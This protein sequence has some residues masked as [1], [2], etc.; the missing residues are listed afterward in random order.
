MIAA[1]AP[2]TFVRDY[3][4]STDGEIGDWVDGPV[5]DDN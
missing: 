3:A 4:I 1:S 5:D 2:R